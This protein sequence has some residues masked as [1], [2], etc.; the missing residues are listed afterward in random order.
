MRL[1]AMKL[2]SM[3]WI[4]KARGVIVTTERVIIAGVT[5]RSEMVMIVA[6]LEA[7]LAVLKSD[8]TEEDKEYARQVAADVR[9]RLIQEREGE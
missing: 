5:G 4:L 2:R 6:Q 7:Q 3:Y 8:M 9:V 1:L